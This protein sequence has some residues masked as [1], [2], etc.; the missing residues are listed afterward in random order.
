MCLKADA[1]SMPLAFEP[2]ILI[3]LQAELRQTRVCA[4]IWRKQAD[5]STFGFWG[6]ARFKFPQKAVCSF[7]HRLAITRVVIAQ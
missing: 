4:R 6:S 1:D 2:N 3:T 7:F 5:G